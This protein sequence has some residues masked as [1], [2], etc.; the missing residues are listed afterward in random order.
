MDLLLLQSHWKVG[1]I[2]PEDLHKAATELLKAG[3][4]ALLWSDLLA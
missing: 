4:E 2:R 1:S 3:I